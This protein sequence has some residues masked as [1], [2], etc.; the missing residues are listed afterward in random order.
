MAGW[1]R[2]GHRAARDLHGRSGPRLEVGEF[3]LLA[4]MA[5]ERAAGEFL[6]RSNRA[7]TGIASRF[8]FGWDV[9][10]DLAQESYAIAVRDDHA[11]L[12]RARPATPL[13]AWIGG[14]VWRLASARK[15]A[16]LARRRAM[17]SLALSRPNDSTRPTDPS[18]SLGCGAPSRAHP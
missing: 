13:D 5:P 11:A 9:A 7:A 4:A 1:E 8:G 10:E 2:D 17:Q 6:S 12:R 15:Q 14:V 18:T 16:D 3:R